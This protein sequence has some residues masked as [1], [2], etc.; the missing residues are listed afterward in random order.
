M[1]IVINKTKSNLDSFINNNIKSYLLILSI[2][3][4]ITRLLLSKLKYPFII[5]I[6]MSLIKYIIENTILS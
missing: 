3:I 5:T 4:L 2:S 6:L 1:E